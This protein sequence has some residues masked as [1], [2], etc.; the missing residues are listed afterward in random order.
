MSTQTTRAR[1]SSSLDKATL[2]EEIEEN[3]RQAKVLASQAY[4]LGDLP[5]VWRM[6]SVQA[7]NAR[8]RGSLA[9]R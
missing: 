1:E 4:R 3:D 2:L 5:T 8:S 6:K 9:N 7:E